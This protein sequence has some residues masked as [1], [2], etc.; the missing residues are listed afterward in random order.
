M[1]NANAIPSISGKMDEV[2]DNNIR[3]LSEWLAEMATPAENPTIACET[4][5]GKLHS[6]MTLFR[7]YSII[8]HAPA[9]I[10]LGIRSLTTCESTIA[11]TES[12]S[13]L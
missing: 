8:S 12:Q 4:R 6:Y 10:S 5:E 7:G 2:I 11:S 3:E 1:P 9:F 13:E